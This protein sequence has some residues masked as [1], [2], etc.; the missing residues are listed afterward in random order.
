MRRTV[1]ELARRV[2]RIHGRPRHMSQRLFEGRR[3]L[4]SHARRAAGDHP[5][6]LAAAAAALIGVAIALAARSTDWEEGIRGRWRG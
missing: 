4:R 2:S 5:A 1:D 6:L 3:S